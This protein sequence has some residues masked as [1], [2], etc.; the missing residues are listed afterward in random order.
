MCRLTL[1]QHP[2]PEHPLLLKDDIP[3]PIG[4]LDGWRSPDA[5]AKYLR[6][7]TCSGCR[8]PGLRIDSIE[9]DERI[10]SSSTKS[11]RALFKLTIQE[12][13]GSRSDAFPID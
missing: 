10:S 1:P 2:G 9:G 5:Y 13:R 4:R 6:L 11:L 3:G 8:C 12:L 7:M